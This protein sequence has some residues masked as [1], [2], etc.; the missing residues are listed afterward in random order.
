MTGRIMELAHTLGQVAPDEEGAL[1]ALCGAAQ[2]ELTGMLRDGVAP[3]D[4]PEAFVVAGAW[5]A[6]AGLEVSRGAAQP[7]SFSAGDVSIHSG[8]A[9]DKAKL[10]R[11]QAGRFM[12]GWTKDNHFLFYGV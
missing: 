5:L 7:E 12:A 9:A 1:A 4:C 8:S 3:L 11:E 2:Q 6:L 10:L